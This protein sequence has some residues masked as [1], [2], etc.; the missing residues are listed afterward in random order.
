MPNSIVKRAT[1]YL[2][3]VP[4][5]EAA[6][7]FGSQA[8]GRVTPL[9]DVDIALHLRGRNGHLYRVVLTGLMEHLETES[10]DLILLDDAPPLLA[11]QVLAHGQLLFC[12]DPCRRAAYEAEIVRRYL[13]FAPLRA[14]QHRYLERRVSEGQMG[15]QTKAWINRQ[16]VLDRIG[17]INKMLGYLERHRRRSCEEFLADEEAGYAAI[18]ELQTA[19]EAVADIGNHII[20]AVG[21]GT[22]QTRQEIMQI[23]G[24]AGV[25]PPDL[26]QRLGLAL[27]MRNILVHGYLEVVMD[28][29]Y[30]ALQEDLGDLAAFCQAVLDYIASE[31]DTSEE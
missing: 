15:R 9:S 12:R 8:E 22:P 25:L 27:R 17:H 11:Y 24:Q 6:Y 20:A 4:E 21:L 16:A 1:E 5:V 31:T 30:Q 2:R 18:Y 29:V 3:T 10:V 28:Q 7:L 26:A 23:L 14:H 19:L 13:D